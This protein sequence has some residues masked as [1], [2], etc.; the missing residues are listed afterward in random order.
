MTANKEANATH[1][2]ITVAIFAAVIPY[3]FSIKL[4]TIK[5]FVPLSVAALISCQETNT[6]YTQVH[7]QIKNSTSKH[8]NKHTAW[9]IYARVFYFATQMT[10]IVIAQI[11]ING[12]N[13]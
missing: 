6:G 9:N 4:L 1:K 5:L 13:A 7:C 3:N 2:I 8:G 11:T 12:F 10:N